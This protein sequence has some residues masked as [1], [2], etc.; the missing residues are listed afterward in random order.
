VSLTV[1]G[2]DGSSQEIEQNYKYRSA[3]LRTDNQDEYRSHF[4]DSRYGYKTVV[5]TT[6]AKINPEELKYARMFYN[7]CFSGKY[8]IDSFHRG[9]MFYTT[10]NSEG[11]IVPEYIQYYLRGYTDEQLL[12]WMNTTSETEDLYDYYDFTQRPPS[13]R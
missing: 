12:N 8:F 13:M 7:T 6:A 11:N 1:Y 5:D 3:N 2:P 10:W 9:K 4:E